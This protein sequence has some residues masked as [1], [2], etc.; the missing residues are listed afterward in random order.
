MKLLIVGAL[1]AVI[2]AIKL[3]AHRETNLPKL[4]QLRAQENHEWWIFG[5][6]DQ[7]DQ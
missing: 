6:D 4:H 3:D 1:L 7:S 5:N 2:S